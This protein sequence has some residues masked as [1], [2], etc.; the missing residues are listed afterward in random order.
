ML[1]QQRRNSFVAASLT[2]V[3]SSALTLGVISLGT[4]AG[5]QEAYGKKD[6]TCSNA[7]LKGTYGVLAEGYLGTELPLTYA[8]GVRT[9]VFDGKGNFNGRGYVSANGIISQF[10]TPGTYEVSSDCTVTLYSTIV[11][12]LGGESN[13][14]GV[15]VDGGKEIYTSRTDT[16]VSVNAVFK[17]VR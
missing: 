5:A 13:Q 1:L 2:A 11:G 16:G 12:G 9:A 15:I 17:R 14:F 10:T 8:N 7:T 3:V 6:Y 4:S